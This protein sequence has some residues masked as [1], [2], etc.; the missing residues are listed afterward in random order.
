ME[1]IYFGEQFIELDLKFVELIEDI[2][3]RYFDRP[4]QGPQE[5][6]LPL[7]TAI[8]VKE[9]VEWELI[10]AQE[11]ILR[12]TFA[13]VVYLHVIES[14]IVLLGLEL[15]Q[16]HFAQLRLVSENVEVVI[17]QDHASKVFDDAEAIEQSLSQWTSWQVLLECIEG[18]LPGP[19]PGWI[20]SFYGLDDVI[21]IVW[22]NDLMIPSR[23]SA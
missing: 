23:L 16:S 18:K 12:D 20:Y 5:A 9:C 17:H 8:E 1:W 3:V 19:F 4:D 22:K 15:F 11:P 10:V 21:V 7:I 13:H 2:Y 6:R 14:Q